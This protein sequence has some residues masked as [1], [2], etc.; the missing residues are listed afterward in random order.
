[1]LELNDKPSL[2]KARKRYSAKNSG[3]AG[4]W[5]L[6]QQFATLPTAFYDVML[7]D[8]PGSSEGSTRILNT[9][10][11]FAVSIKAQL[12][13]G[14]DRIIDDLVQSKTLKPALTEQDLQS[15]RALVF[16]MLG[17][18]T[19]LYQPSFGTS[20]PEQFSIT[21]DFDGYHGQ[22]FLA[23]KQDTSSAKRNLEDFLMGFGLV[24]PPRNTCISEDIEERQAFDSVS[25][26]D[27]SELNASILHEIAHVNFKWVDSLA[28]HMEYNKAMNTLYLFRYP[29]FCAA[30]LPQS[31]KNNGSETT[32]SVLHCCASKTASS[33]QWVSEE[34]VTNFLCEVLLSY[35]LLFGQSKE[36]RQ[37]FRRLVQAQAFEDIPSHAH[38]PLLPLLC[39]R[40]STDLFGHGKERS[41]YRVARD[42]PMLRFRIAVLKKQ[43][44]I[45]KPRG[46]KE[47]WRDKRDSAQWVTFW[48]VI[49]IGGLGLLLSLLQV[50]IGVLQVTIPNNNS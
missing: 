7:E 50:I 28:S 17:W 4:E 31:S 5:W 33:Q 10:L 23:F 48:A 35:R 14:I 32:K 37:Y 46:W 15:C 25:T 19:M 13:P 1:M 11:Q 40:K 24:I 18:Q 22:A 12:E 21:D 45:S 20:P 9:F 49:I 47:L 34:D 43:L 27:S 6:D 26:V 29:S 8:A 42:F 38:D 44:A 39:G 3:Y 41:T 30:N 2:H 16:A 36:A